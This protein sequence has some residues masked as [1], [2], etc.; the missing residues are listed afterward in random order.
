MREYLPRHMSL[1]L[2]DG[3]GQLNDLRRIDERLVCAAVPLLQS[4]GICLRYSNSLHDVAGDVVPAEIDR[5]EIADFPLVENGDVR[6]AR[7]HLDERN[8]QLLFVFG[9]N[10]QCARQ[11]FQ[12]Q[13][14]HVIAGALDRLAKVH[15]RRRADGDEIHLGL[16]SRADHSDRIAYSLVLVD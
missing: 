2:R 11:R 8:T 12:H 9:E 1:A 7:S 14:S 6:R 16:Q 15:R 5:P 4:L 13:L 10:A 3:A